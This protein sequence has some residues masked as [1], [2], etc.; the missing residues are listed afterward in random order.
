MCRAVPSRVRMVVQRVWQ[1]DWKREMRAE[2]DERRGGRGW[3]VGWE[4][5]MLKALGGGLEGGVCLWGH[6][7]FTL[8]D[9]LAKWMLECCMNYMDAWLGLTLWP[10][11]S[12]ASPCIDTHPRFLPP[13]FSEWIAYSALCSA[14]W[15][16]YLRDSI[17]SAPFRPEVA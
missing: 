8:L 3:R 10:W 15:W 9:R 5:A 1:E 14:G 2:E 13:A 17:V 11:G 6:R 4:E 16:K 12:R 7:D